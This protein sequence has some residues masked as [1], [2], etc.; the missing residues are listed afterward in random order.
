MPTGRRPC[1]GSSRGWSGA[2]PPVPPDTG[3][4]TGAELQRGSPLAG[5]GSE[6]VVL[7]DDRRTPEA[8]ALRHPL[9]SGAASLRRMRY[10]ELG[11]LRVSCVGLGCSKFGGQLDLQ[12]TRAVIDAALGAGINFLDTA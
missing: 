4:A 10:R 5:S 8:R 2:C 1:G 9:G 3:R 7:I 11:D 12:G 6:L